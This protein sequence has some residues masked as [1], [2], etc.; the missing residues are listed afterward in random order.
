MADVQGESKA[1]DVPV[2]GGPVRK[3]N[4]MV[5]NQMGNEYSK[6]FERYSSDRKLIEQKWLRNLRQYLGIYDPEVERL[7]QAN[8]SRAYPRITRVKCISLLSRVMNLM[9]PGNERNWE[10]KASPSADMD[11]D[12]V[13][14]AVEDLMKLRQQQGLQTE[15][16]EEL[17]EAA[18]QDVA[19]K[20]AIELSKLID[21][22][23]QELG[24]DQTEDYILIN[25]RVLVSGIRYGAG[26]LQGPFIREEPRT[27]WQFTDDGGVEP[28]E[29]VLYKPQ[30][31]NVSIWDYYP[32]MAARKAPGDG[33]FLRKIMSKT[34]LRE[35][36][37]REDFFSDQIKDIIRSNPSGNYKAQEFEEQLR[38]MGNK[39]HVDDKNRDHNDKYEVIVWN[40]PIPA[41]KLVHMGADVPEENKADRLD[42]ELWMVGRRVIKADL[43]PWVRLGVDV[44]TIH[45]FIFD[46]NDTSPLGDGLP[47]A[48]RDSQMAVCAAARMSLDNAAITCGPNLEVN[49]DLLKMDQ[50]ITQI[51]PYKIWYREGLDQ[52]AG[53][54]A[55]RKV[56]IDGHLGE[57]QNL[58][59][60][61]MQFADQ[62]TFI[63]PATGGDMTAMPSEPMRTA[64][65]A[66]MVRGDAALPF[67]DIVR[68]FDSFTQSVILSLVAFN[69]K[70][71]PGLAPEGDYN[72]IARG[73][74]SLVA[75][76]VRA[77]QVDALAQTLTDEEKDHIDSRKLARSRLAARDMEDM[78][79][80]DSQAQINRDQR[81]AAEQDQ[82]QQMREMAA[83]QLREILSEAYKNIT[84]GQKNT[85]NA[86]ATTA[87]AALDI[88]TR[89]VEVDNEQNTRPGEQAA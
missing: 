16:N 67:K 56:E 26:V 83:A 24:G 62:E 78:L 48:M 39:A 43:N 80:S 45:T 47:D 70:Y 2:E 27:V 73:A 4:K 65:G 77:M 57:L 68:N 84:Q 13:M 54:P 19:E 49:L 18:V 12:E 15:P 72:I 58:M 44:K 8:S 30:F 79:V 9:F 6:L 41:D 59:T 25:R 53:V 66:S 81:M 46:E 74:T 38:A 86:Q 23:L 36:A 22:Q 64:A 14:A 10:I 35:L 42:A 3:I 37:D 69:K 31:E 17:L 50:D 60:V 52:A 21:D 5:L 87:T 32:D 82:M 51:E 85:A 1:P 88:L 33:Y 28:V 20:R 61:F 29:R 11:P 76:E 55:V 71:N 40:G 34:G 75:K 63:G 89:S 7:L